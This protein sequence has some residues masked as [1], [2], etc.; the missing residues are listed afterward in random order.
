MR[1]KEPW[2]QRF[3]CCVSFSLRSFLVVL[4]LISCAC[5]YRGLT[6]D[7]R[8]AQLGFSVKSDKLSENGFGWCRR[9]SFGIVKDE[10]KGGVAW[11]PLETDTTLNGEKDI[12]KKKKKN[13]M[14]ERERKKSRKRRKREGR[15]ERRRKKKC[16]C[17]LW[18]HKQDWGE[19]G[20]A[21]RL[22]P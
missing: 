10:G 12:K 14:I 20:G 16:L 15:K 6:L 7:A 8:L 1:K 5:V 9:R 22:I 13:K 11:W 18:I 17:I 4:C 2:P 21:G 19:G 3:G